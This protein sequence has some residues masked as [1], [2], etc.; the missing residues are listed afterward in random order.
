MEFRSFAPFLINVFFF[1][2]Y[3]LNYI[4][5]NYFKNNYFVCVCVCECIYVHMYIC[6][7]VDVNRKLV[8]GSQFLPSTCCCCAAYSW[9]ASGQS[10]SSACH[11]PGLQ[12]IDVTLSEGSSVGH[13]AVELQLATIS[14]A[15]CLL[16]TR[17]VRCL[18]KYTICWCAFPLCRLP[19]PFLDNV[20]I[21]GLI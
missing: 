12:I 18:V 6:S 10:V 21:F 3:V 20:K 1:R 11:L 5:F 16:S 13:Q 8:G 4:F 15:V 7:P 17:S 19:L 9:P 2:M 14:S